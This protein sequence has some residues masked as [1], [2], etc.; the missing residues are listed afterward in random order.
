MQYSGFK[1]VIIIAVSYPCRVACIAFI[2]VHG[3]IISPSAVISRSLILPCYGEPPSPSSRRRRH[4][5]PS[6]TDTASGER[7]W[8]RHPV[9]GSGRQTGPAC[10][11]DETHSRSVVIYHYHYDKKIVNKIIII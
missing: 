11:P 7:A 4:P 10:R 1:V 6:H 5:G 3:A 9:R 2:C 8:S